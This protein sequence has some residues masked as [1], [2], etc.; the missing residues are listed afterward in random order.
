LAVNRLY[1]IEFWW[2]EVRY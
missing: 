1:T 2:Q